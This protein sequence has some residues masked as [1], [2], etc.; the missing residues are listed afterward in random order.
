MKNIKAVIN[1]IYLTLFY[2]VFY[3]EQRQGLMIRKRIISFIIVSPLT[4]PFW[5]L[6]SVIDYI[7]YMIEYK[8]AWIE[9]DKNKKLT[10]KQRLAIKLN[11]Q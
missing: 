10:F 1:I 3:S 9:Y 2:K 8:S 4:I 6:C 5:A 7:N 11:L